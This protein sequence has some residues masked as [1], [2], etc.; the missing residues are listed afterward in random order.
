[1]TKVLV[2]GGS[3]FLGVNLIEMLLSAGHEVISLDI[4]PHPSNP[5]GKFSF[6]E[7]D[8]R[9]YDQVLQLMLGVDVVVHAAAKLPLASS[10]EIF[11]VDVGGTDVVTRAAEAMGVAS[12][13]L[14]SST[15]VYGIPREAF[16]DESQP[17]R[18]VGPYGKAKV[19]AEAIAR[20]NLAKTSLTILRPKSFI[21]PERLGI[22]SLLFDW[23]HSGLRFPIIGKG[24]NRLQLLD[25]EDLCMV[26][27]LCS[28]KPA[29]KIRVLNVGATDF[30]SLADDF[31]FVL[32]LA[33]HGKKLVA[34]PVRISVFLLDLAYRLGL[35]PVYPWIY[36][37][38]IKDSIVNVDKLS[39]ELGFRPKFSNKQS[40]ERSF[41]WYQSKVGTTPFSK[42]SNHTSI[43]SS[44][45]TNALKVFFS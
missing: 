20:R 41:R 7:V 30:G 10:K 21:G 26:I 39:H 16:I 28:E 43:W 4:L 27:M 2:T 18:G 12:V 19:E 24:N 33:G 31:Q 44:N 38:M 45:L 37:S 29:Q 8:V 6:H 13:I 32:D 15:A 36:K 34:A 3:G 14:I 11:S 9:E 25:V 42:G 40:L 22:F 23:A 5:G 17:L 35:S 1:M